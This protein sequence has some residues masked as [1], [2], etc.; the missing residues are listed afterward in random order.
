MQPIQKLLRSQNP[1]RW[2]FHG[3]S[4]THGAYHTMGWRN[5]SELFTERIRWELRRR[6][7]LILNTAYSGFTTENLLD[8]FESQVARFE[9]QVVFFMIGMNDCCQLNG[10]A[11]VPLSA[12][13]R[14]LRELVARTRAINEAIPVLQTTCPIEAKRVPDRRLLPRYMDAI[15]EIATSAKAPLIDHHLHWTQQSLVQVHQLNAWMNDAFHP[16]AMGHRVFAETIF[17]RLGIFDKSS[18]TCRLFY[19]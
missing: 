16:N 8:T 7:D 11:D 14:N 10:K 1:V 12:F 4:I 17:K 2:V 19:A 3:D 6:D 18:T 15:R 9:P 13:K 5:Y